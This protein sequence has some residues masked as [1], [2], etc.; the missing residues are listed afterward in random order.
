MSAVQSTLQSKAQTSRLDAQSRK[1]EII[2][3]LSG[4]STDAK[5]FEELKNLNTADAD[6]KK[7][8]QT[9]VAQIVK[10][11][12]KEGITIVEL[13]KVGGALLPDI[14]HLYDANTIRASAGT[15]IKAPRKSG[16]GKAEV[17]A[18]RDRAVFYVQA[19][20]GDPLARGPGLSI[21]KGELPTKFG[22]KLAWLKAQPGDLKANLMNTAVKNDEMKNYL[23]SSVG[24][25][26][27]DDVVAFI[28]QE[29]KPTN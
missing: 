26:F 4:G 3:L 12:A 29:G 5:L 18:P 22:P 27:L 20:K 6:A 9:L 13:V 11:M 10:E 21:L 23:A 19:T 28:A 16:G 15:A 8:R 24:K 2:A 7:H 25:K 1:S 17:V 14:N